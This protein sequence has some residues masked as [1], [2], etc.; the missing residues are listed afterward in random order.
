MTRFETPGV[1]VVEG[2][3]FPNSVVEV[4]TAV[5][6]FIG[7]TEKAARE[8]HPLH[9]T[10]TRITSLDEYRTYFGGAPQISFT[11]ARS[12][13][14]GGAEEGAPPYQL[15]RTG[16]HYHLYRSLVAF[17]HNGGGPC[18]IVSVGTYADQD[19]ERVALSA[20]IEALQD[21]AEP[22]LVVI[23]DA[24]LL[25]A[26]ACYTV[27]RE[28][29]E[30][31]AD[32]RSRIAILDVHGG[33]LPQDESPDCIEAFRAAM[34]STPLSWAAAYYPWLDTSIVRRSELRTAHLGDAGRTALKSLLLEEVGAADGDAPS[35]TRRSAATLELIRSIPVGAVIPPD[36][37]D[38]ARAAREADEGSR[39][40]AL[41]AVS[42]L[43]GDILDEML[44]TVNRLPPS[45][46]IAGV[47][48][49]TDNARGVWKAP[50]NVGL[51]AVVQPTV[52]VS[53]SEQQ[54]L[55][56]P[57]SGKSVNAI[58]TFPGEGTRIWGARTLDG[59]SLDFRYVN[60]RRTM[61]MLE[62]SITLACRALVFEP[63]TADTWGTIK[64]MIRNF[65]TGLWKRGGLAGA[66]A[67]EAFS[68][69]VGLG[70]TMTAQDLADGLLR[71]SV[72]VAIVRPAEF[73]AFTV[74]V[75]MVPD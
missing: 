43:F 19:V 46:A 9:R 69:Q 26:D 53:H 39:T 66:K 10:P 3:P 17:Y 44:R 18:Y 8:Q 34:T 30:H 50:A 2:D 21:E 56:A 59:N 52:D 37:T 61:I 64:A 51:G 28:A 4:A 14:P 70:E 25:P 1:Y 68:V 13:A 54:D 73:M 42:P 32:A 5:P 55:N 75:G 36:E 22:T 23:P 16:A 74:E 40:E 41:L 11:L 7:Y 31:C 48:T 58:R 47:Y 20:G 6:A 71:V 63:N 29:I 62:Q 57:A 12:A 15:T 27:Q 72:F 38:D 24:V 45:G 65:L 35:V 60:V 49:L 33:Y 67:D